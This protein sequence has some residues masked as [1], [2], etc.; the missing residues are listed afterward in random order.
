MD[1]A[2]VA[3]LTGKIIVVDPKKFYGYHFPKIPQN[4]LDALK[5]DP[6]NGFVPPDPASAEP[7]PKK[8]RGRKKGRTKEDDSTT[9]PGAWRTFP[10]KPKGEDEMTDWFGKMSAL[11]YEKVEEL[12]QE[13]SEFPYKVTST[14]VRHGEL[15]V[16]TLIF[17]SY[18][19]FRQS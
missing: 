3:E 16:G 7:E 2:L 5:N 10:K 17:T 15:G 11:I 14:F 9:S 18:S 6:V 13:D 12:D 19:K 8:G 4:L 1:P